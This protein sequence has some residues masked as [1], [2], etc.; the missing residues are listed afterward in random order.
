M[1]IVNE[2]FIDDMIRRREQ[3]GLTQMSKHS[4]SSIP[5]SKKID[6]SENITRAG[7]QND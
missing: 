4:R 6:H 2:E 3:M 5:T 1:R 7:L